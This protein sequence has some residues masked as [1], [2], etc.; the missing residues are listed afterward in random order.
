[1]TEVVADV[2]PQPLPDPDTEGFWQATARGE[3][4]ICRCQ[5]CGRWQHPPVE[6]CP[7]CAGPTAFEPVGGEGSVFSFIVANRASV[8]GF[9]QFVPYAV[10]LVELDEQPGLRV[11]S[12]L[13]GIDPHAVEIGMRVRAEIVDLPGGDYRVAVFHRV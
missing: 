10:A 4:A 6:R 1:V 13:A 8:P 9:A 11:V 7:E 3:L 5:A 2:P 12:R